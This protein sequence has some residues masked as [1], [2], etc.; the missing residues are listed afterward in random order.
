MPALLLSIVLSVLVTSL[1]P[2]NAHAWGNPELL[3]E[4][5]DTSM[6]K[7]DFLD[8]WEIWKEADTPLPETPDD[9][10]DW[11]LLFQ[12]AENMQFYDQSAYI[13][14]VSVFLRSRSLMLLKQEEQ[15]KKEI[16]VLLAESKPKQKP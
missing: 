12:E 4:L 14:K 2:A 13:R 3:V 16:K 7:Q 10:I 11:M 8:W 1:L 9:F 6:N 15:L 5:N